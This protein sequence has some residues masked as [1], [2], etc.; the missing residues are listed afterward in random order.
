MSAAAE[1][2]HVEAQLKVGYVHEIGFGVVQD[3]LRAAQFY[4]EAAN[5]GSAEVNA[6][7]LTSLVV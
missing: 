3:Y 6:H 1:Q 2:N 4:E 7:L 5:S